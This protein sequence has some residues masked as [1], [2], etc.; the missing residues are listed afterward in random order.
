MRLPG[1]ELLEAEQIHSGLAALVAFTVAHE[2][3]A[4]IGVDVGLGQRERFGDP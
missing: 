2:D 3:S 4:L 1:G